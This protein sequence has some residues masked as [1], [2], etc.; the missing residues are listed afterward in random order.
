[1]S[2]FIVLFPFRPG[3]TSTRIRAGH[4]PVRPRHSKDREPFDP[5]S[6]RTPGR[7]RERTRMVNVAHSRLLLLRR[8]RWPFSAEYALRIIAMRFRPL[9]APRAV[10]RVKPIAV[11]AQRVALRASVARVGCRGCHVSMRIATELRLGV[12]R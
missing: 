3:G 7:R 4:L 12:R 8:F 11:T 2:R 1:M 6:W 9:F 5:V 10:K